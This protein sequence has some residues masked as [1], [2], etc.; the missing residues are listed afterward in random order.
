MAKAPFMRPA[1]GSTTAAYYIK[2]VEADVRSAMRKL[3]SENYA[4]LPARTRDSDYQSIESVRCDSV[5]G[6]YEIYAAL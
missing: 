5:K 2:T 1:E 3:E 4:C 6:V